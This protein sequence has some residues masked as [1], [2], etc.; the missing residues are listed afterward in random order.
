MFP[1]KVQRPKALRTTMRE[2]VRAII[3]NMLDE[4]LQESFKQLKTEVGEVKEEEPS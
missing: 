2:R 4:L 1:P 3:Q